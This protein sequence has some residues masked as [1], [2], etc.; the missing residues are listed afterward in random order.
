MVRDSHERRVPLPV[1]HD[2]TDWLSRH[3][4]VVPV[5]EIP[6]RIKRSAGNPSAEFDAVRETPIRFGPD[7][8]LFGILT[9]PAETGRF[10]RDGGST[11]ILMLNVGTN[12]RVGPNRL[13]VRMARHW[14]RAGYHTLRF[15][16]AGMGDS[17]AAA[18]YTTARLYSKD[19]VADVQAAIDALAAHGCERFV[20]LGLCSGAYAAFQTTLADPRVVAQVLLNPRRLSFAK[21]DTLEGVMS[22]SYKSSRYY[23]RALLAPRTYLRLLRGEVD[24]MGIGKRMQALVTARLTRMRDRVLGR[25]A[26]DEDVLTNVKLL[27]RRGVES[28]FVVGA[29]DDGL[30]Y[31]EFHLGAGGRDVRSPRFHMELVS[32]SDHTF[33]RSQSQ[34][35]LIDYVTEQ[36][37]RKLPAGRPASRLSGRWASAR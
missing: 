20:L 24:A 27:C 23:Q 21:G 34:E 12:H 13:Y 29:E 35:E 3:H 6:P 18:G 11:A 16:L 17:R 2:I 4:P 28:L 8:G 37:S 14:A 19:S 31:L 10:S 22:E 36:L 30:D 5:H 1:L 32:N 7:E 15:D 33:S 26:S 9:E 25:P